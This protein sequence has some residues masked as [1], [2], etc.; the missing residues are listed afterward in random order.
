MLSGEAKIEVTEDQGKRYIKNTG[1]FT[2]IELHLF[3]DQP[4]FDERLP[5]RED[6]PELNFNEKRIEVTTNEE[7]QEVGACMMH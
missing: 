7:W 6:R 4:Y 5:V 2:G 1:T 3:V